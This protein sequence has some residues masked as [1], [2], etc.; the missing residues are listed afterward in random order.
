MTNV[1]VFMT[2]QQRGSTIDPAHPVRAITPRI[3]K[4]RNTGVTFTR[5]YA[6]SPHCCPS[7]ASFFTSRYP[8]E[9][10]VWNNVNV[11]N[12]LSRGPRE[13]VAFW[14]Q[15]FAEAGYQLGF[16]GKWHVSNSQSPEVFGWDELFLHPPMP[17]AASSK[18][19]EH[20]TARNA[21]WAELKNSLAS[22][23]ASER[24]PGE[25][26]RPGWPQYVQYG[27]DEAPFRDDAVTDQAV[28]FIAERADG[29]RPWMLYVGTLGP[30]D[31]YTP[32]Q[33]FLDMYDPEEITLPASFLDPLI[34][35]PALYRRTRD[36][37]DQLSLEEHR[38]SLRHY[39]AFCS[40]EDYLFGRLLD[41]LE[42]SGELEN[43]LVLY[44]SDHGDYTGE[45]GLWAKGLPSFDAAY[46][47]PL[48]IGGANISTRAAGTTCDVPVSLVDLGPTLL[49]ECGVT[50]RTRPSGFSLSAALRGQALNLPRNELVFQS[51]GNEA[52]GIQRIVMTDNWKLVYNM[53][54]DD[55]LYDRVADPDEMTNLLAPTPGRSLGAAP[56]AR[57]PAHLRTTVR[58]LYERLWRFAKEH[59]DDIIN[60]YIV[61]AFAHFGP[62]T[63]AQA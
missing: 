42:A 59:E 33:R 1:L 52:Y 11:S 55:E 50:S 12:A 16:S 46:N 54:D 4:F 24:M 23:D 29:E 63:T 60:S 62:T 2:D 5:A 6:P 22:S 44:V 21:E 19:S 17:A 51:N 8:S 31:P 58:D 35:K 32:P 27:V 49:E 47:V 14:S 13:Q 57:I 20:T 7:R 18:E 10:G 45:H 61:T 28:S 25:I 43:T 39:L 3:D 53:F 38:E 40:Y 30:H 15:D 26:I 56:S 48:V 36:P 9:H 41:E 37:F 34:D